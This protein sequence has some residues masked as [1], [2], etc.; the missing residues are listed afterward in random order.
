[1]KIIDN[2]SDIYDSLVYQYGIDPLLTYVRHGWK[3]N[4]FNVRLPELM[5]NRII[6]AKNLTMDMYHRNSDN[7]PSIKH[8]VIGESVI[9]V[10]RKGGE[11]GVFSIDY[12]EECAKKYPSWTLLKYFV[13]QFQDEELILS[14]MIGN[15]VG[16][17]EFVRDTN[18]SHRDANHPIR[19]DYT[20]IKLKD[21]KGLAKVISLNQIYQNITHALSK[22]LDEKPLTEVS[23]EIKIMQAGFDTKQSFRH[24]K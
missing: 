13:P 10:Y 22:Q 6:S 24:R 18:Y 4:S 11:Y 12:Q 7:Y 15:P 23:N 14:N 21:I 5:R 19:I 20:P 3:A 16:L 1:M 8:I 2:D 17:I 9:T